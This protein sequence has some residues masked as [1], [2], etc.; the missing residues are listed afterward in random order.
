MP[1]GCTALGHAGD[2]L[3]AILSDTHMPRGG[4]ALPPAC[5][6]H[7]R[8]AELILHAGDICTASVLRDLEAIGPP[9]HAVHGNVDEHALQTLLP[10]TLELELAGVRVA[11]THDAGPSQGRLAR[12]RGRFPTASGVIFGHSHMPAL[13]IDRGGFALFN[14]GSP[15]ERRRA[16]RHTMGIARIGDGSIEFELVEVQIGSPTP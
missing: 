4:R 9:L 7:L 10:A 12:M 1:P 3:I 11:M 5:V 15:T 2:V 13:E 16:A 14:P 6:E 8:R